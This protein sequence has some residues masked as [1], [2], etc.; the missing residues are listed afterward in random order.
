M[1]LNFR[2]SLTMSLL[3]ADCLKFPTFTDEGNVEM[4]F[5][6][7]SG[8]SD[9]I[10][11][12]LRKAIEE[13]AAFYSKGTPINLMVNTMLPG[14]CSPT[15]RDWIKSPKQ[16]VNACIA[17]F[18]LPIQTNPEAKWWD[19]HHQ[20]RTL[21]E[22]AWYGPMP[23]WNKHRVCNFGI[24]PRIHLIVDLDTPLPLGCYQ[25]D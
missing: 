8:I 25:D 1:I 5:V 18:H 15:H 17:R 11:A 20:Y 12:Y 6:Q 24:T 4:A 14:K 23:Y 22:G 3:V 9:A 21:E 16:G 19:E 7:G 2:S 13:I 10:P